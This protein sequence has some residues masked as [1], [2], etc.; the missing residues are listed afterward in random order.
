MIF[1]IPVL[2][3]NLGPKRAQLRIGRA[4]KS[5]LDSPVHQNYLAKTIDWV[6][7]LSVQCEPPSPRWSSV[8]EVSGLA[9]DRLPLGQCGRA[10]FLVSLS[11]DEMTFEGEKIV[12]VGM[13]RGELL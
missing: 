7:A 5:D 6:D 3:K 8:F 2:R 10:A 4:K 13:D 11:I 12:D 9:R 1:K